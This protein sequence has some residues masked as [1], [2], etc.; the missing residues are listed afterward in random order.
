MSE[1]YKKSPKTLRRYFDELEFLGEKRVVKGEKKVI[2]MDATFFGR[3]YGI[4]VARSNGKNVAWVEIEKETKLEYEKLLH[5]MEEMGVEF[6]AFVID[7]KKGI[8][9]TLKRKYPNIPIQVCQFHQKKF[10]IRNVSLRPQSE[11][12]KELK[13]IVSSLTRTNKEEYLKKIAEFENK[14]N[15][16]IEERVVNKNK[17]KKSTEIKSLDLHMHL[18]KIIVI[19]YLHI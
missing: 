4:L 14:W 15:D 8:R 5:K 16:L 9:E 18:L 19:I 6:G 2:I 13:E 17:K 11:W 1:K 10:I 12:G 7:G 3:E